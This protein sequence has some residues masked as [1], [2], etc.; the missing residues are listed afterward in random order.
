MNERKKE[1]DQKWREANREWQKQYDRNLTPEQKAAHSKAQSARKKAF[2]KNFI[3]PPKP[4]KVPPSGPASPFWKSEEEKRETKNAARRRYYAN[5]KAKARA[6]DALREAAKAQRTPAWFGEFDRFVFEEA[7]SLLP[8]RKAATGIDW[9]VDHMI[10]LRAPTVSGLHVGIN[11][12]VIPAVLNVR[13]SDQLI[14]TNTGDWL[15]L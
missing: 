10:P 15:R 4:R 7:Y 9:H 2:R 13:K 1:Y 14:L 6:K 5:H 11:A 12:A 8:V 3:G